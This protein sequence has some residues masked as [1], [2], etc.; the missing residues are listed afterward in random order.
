MG[1]NI[2]TAATSAALIPAAV[3]AAGGKNTP[4]KKCAGWW[5]RSKNHSIERRSNGESPIPPRPEP[6]DR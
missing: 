4:T 5:R 6:A 2:A 1:T 3:Q